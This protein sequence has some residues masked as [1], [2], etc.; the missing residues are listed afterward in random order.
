M[1][2]MSELKTGRRRIMVFPEI[3]MQRFL[4]ESG[5]DI[6]RIFPAITP[7]LVL[8]LAKPGSAF[9]RDHVF[10]LGHRS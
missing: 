10:P 6:A 8:S 1:V 9:R 4:K 5:L 7:H 2:P 3:T